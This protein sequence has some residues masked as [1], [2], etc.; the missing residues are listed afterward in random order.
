MMYYDEIDYSDIDRDTVP[1][2]ELEKYEACR[3]HI[4]TIVNQIYYYGNI[5]V[6]EEA[7][8]EICGIYDIKMPDKDPKIKR[9]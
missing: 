3:S 9:R 6:L 4:E 1:I 2:E 5:P 8:D 7:L